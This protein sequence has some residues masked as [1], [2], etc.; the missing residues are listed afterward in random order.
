[1]R[2][3]PQPN[4][5]R[6]ILRAIGAVLVLVVL[7]VGAI[8][9]VSSITASSVHAPTVPP[10][11]G[12]IT[13]LPSPS[14]TA[15]PRTTPIKPT[16]KKKLAS[17][18]AGSRSGGKVLALYLDHGLIRAAAKHRLGAL[19]GV[20]P[21]RHSPLFAYFAGRQG[22]GTKQN[23]VI[24]R[25]GSALR[26]RIGYADPLVRPIWS[27]DA[28][29]LLYVRVAATHSFPGARWT[30]VRLDMRT[31][32]EVVVARRNAMALTPLG[33]SGGRLL[34]TVANTT[35]TSIFSV[36]RRHTEF[37][38][39]LMPQP[40]TTA[41]LSSDGRFV[42]LGAPTDCSWCTLDIYDLGSERVWSGPSGMPDESTLAW[43]GNGR[44]V[45][46]IFGHR[47]AVVNVMT[48][49]VRFS[50]LP[51][52]LPSSWNHPM[53]ASV[54]RQS[55]KLTDAVTGAKYISILSRQ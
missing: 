32:R 10:T 5:R 24:G 40:L 3:R 19:N 12:P 33:W 11:V 37:L 13:P 14:A 1:L 49:H 15:A 6:G 2:R 43:T 53:D 51:R 22:V 9:V 47:L 52:D 18:R 7:L 29:H 17:S 26:R 27:G 44:D 34:Y 23:L 4:P 16:P 46:T 36:Y 28:R 39:V 21:A 55:I 42:A 31:G 25:R 30:L 8:L 48:K 54:S 38:N 45:V 20:T 50:R 41:L 35:D